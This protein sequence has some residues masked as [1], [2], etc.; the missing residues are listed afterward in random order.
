MLFQI[1]QVAVSLAAILLVAWLVGRLGLGADV[2]L[3]GE[4]QARELAR[5][6]LCGFEPA[7]VALDRA[8]IG[9]LLR[10]ADGR[11]ML[12][13]RHGAQPVVRAG[14][15]FDL[16]PAVSDALHAALPAGTPLRALGMP[17]QHAAARL[18]LHM[19][20]RGTGSA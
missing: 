19:P 8:G 20:T 6:S 9:A 12:L 1:V 18:A 11:V 13:R 10:G 14:R 16:H 3:N 4:D 2:R 15:V 5:A 7:D 17:A